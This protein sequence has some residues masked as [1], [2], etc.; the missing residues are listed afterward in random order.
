MNQI[1]ILALLFAVASANLGAD[2]SYYSAGRTTFTCLA[3]QNVTLTILQIWDETGTVNKDFLTNYIY[4]R[5]AQ[6]PGFDALVMV[7]DTFAAEDLCNGVARALPTHFN[8]T[9]WLNV[10][11]KQGLW[12][13]DTDERISYLESV[14]KTCQ[15]HGLN[16]GV[17]SSTDVWAT[18]MGSQGTGSDTLSAL[19]VWYFNDN[20][21]Q[22]FD[23][24]SYAGFGTW[25]NPQMKNYGTNTY[26]CGSYITSLDYYEN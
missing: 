9:V 19:P 12:S 23:D 4:S 1:Y 13:R 14:A 17:Y 21:V 8:G 22:S 5:D 25:E 15:Q 6:I 24:F 10:Q 18:V 7:N 11:N 26:L 16:P 2:V 20:N 3:Q